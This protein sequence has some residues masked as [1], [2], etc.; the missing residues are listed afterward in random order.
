MHIK[1]LQHALNH[2]L[3]FKKVHRVIQF[4]QSAWMQKYIMLNVELRQKAT[5]DFEKDFFKIMCNAVFGKTMQ[6]VR[7]EKD[8]KLLTINFHRNKLVGQPNYNCTKWFSEDLLATEMRRIKINMNKPIYLGMTILD[9]SKIPMHEFLYDYLRP[10][11]K[12]NI[13]LCYMDTDSFIFNVKT[14]DSYKDISNDNKQRFDTSNIQTN[15]PLKIRVNKKMLGM[16]KDILADFP[17]KEFIGIRPKSYAYLQDNGKIGKRA[18]GIKKCV[19]K[20][21]L[22]FNGYKDCLINNKKLMRSQQVFKS[23]RHVVSTIQM[24]KN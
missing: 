22:G 15:I 13:N 4:D 12:E 24:K 21:N 18:E 10:R 23:E 16:W 3:K 11:Y 19:T 6:N 8:I 2:G 20:K 17:M 14:E 5:N 9:V 1:L 7:S